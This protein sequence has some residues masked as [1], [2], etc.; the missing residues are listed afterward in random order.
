MSCP[1]PSATQGHFLFRLGRS[2]GPLGSSSRFLCS[3][4]AL[5]AVPMLIVPRCSTAATRGVVRAWHQRMCIATSPV[6][7]DYIE[8]PCYRG[9]RRFSSFIKLR[10][11]LV[12]TTR[13]NQTVTNLTEEGVTGAAVSTRHGRGASRGRIP[14]V[15]VAVAFP[16]PPTTAITMREGPC[17]SSTC[18]CRWAP[19]LPSPPLLVSPL[20]PRTATEQA[21]AL[22]KR[23]GHPGAPDDART[24][25]VQY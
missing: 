8:Q 25:V 19:S 13:L 4:G 10:T 1:R 14:S 9:F 6:A 20:E 11:C 23:P 2:L 22:A 16:S 12:R 5:C 18:R 7:V 3:A 17:S 24:V 15:P 21:R